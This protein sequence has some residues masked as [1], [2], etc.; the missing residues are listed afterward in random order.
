M[1]IFNALKIIA[2]YQ[3]LEAPM[4]LLIPLFMGVGAVSQFLLMKKAAGPEK[5]LM[6]AVLC[7]SCIS[8]E[9]CLRIL[10]EAEA[11]LVVLCYMLAL[12]IGSFFGGGGYFIRKKLSRKQKRK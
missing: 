1:H 9:F 2:D 10:P 11:F 3:N 5:W 7:G 4:E 6:I 12:L 8:C